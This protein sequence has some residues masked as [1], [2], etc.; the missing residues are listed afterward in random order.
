VI[1]HVAVFAS[2][3]GASRHLYKAALAPL[4]IAAQY[5]TDR[6]C[7]FWRGEADTPSLSLERADG[8]ATTGSHIAFAASDRQAVDASFAEAFAAGGR[9]RHGP[10]HRAE[11]RAYRAFV[12]DPDGNNVEAVHKEGP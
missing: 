10:R 11:Y 7:E 9:A 4:H 8:E 2:D 6:V 3:F 1:H 5:E 12:S